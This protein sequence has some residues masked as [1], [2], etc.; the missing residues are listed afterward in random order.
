MGT[1]RHVR[2]NPTPDLRP[3]RVDSPLSSGESSDGP[4][5]PPDSHSAFPSPLLPRAHHSP[6]AYPSPM[7]YTPSPPNAIP[8]THLPSPAFPPSPQPSNV[9]LHPAL[10]ALNLAFDVSQPISVQNPALPASTLAAPATSPPLAQ[11]TLCSAQL[12]WAIAVRPTP[13]TSPG[14][15]FVSVAD[16]LA[17]LYTTLRTQIRREEWEA[18]PRVDEVKRAYEARCR[19]AGAYRETEKMKGVRRV[20]VLCGRTRVE[21]VFRGP[22]SKED[23]WFFTSR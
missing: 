3:F 13:S 5:T 7:V 11:M 21:T 18:L 14:S 8:Y 23:V 6:S 20:D 16:V 19:A 12:P 10:A 17:A 9:Y 22:G 1:P 15:R 4:S 2:F